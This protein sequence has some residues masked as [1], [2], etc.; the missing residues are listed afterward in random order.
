MEKIKVH[1]PIRVTASRFESSLQGSTSAGAGRKTGLMID[2][3]RGV[4]RLLKVIK[5]L[6]G[7]PDNGYWQ[8]LASVG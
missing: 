3:A 4:S 6:I 8:C 2:E 7:I 5:E 1:F